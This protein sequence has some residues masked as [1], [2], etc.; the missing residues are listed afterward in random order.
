M[1]PTHITKDSIKKALIYI[2]RYGIPKDRHSVK[3]SLKYDGKLYPPK[4]VISIANKF[5]S[6]E[7]WEPEHFSGGQET[8]Q[9][10]ENL[11]FTIVTTG[12]RSIVYPIESHSWRGI[13]DTVAIKVLDKSAF[14]HHGSGVPRDFKVFFGL[15]KLAPDQKVDITLVHKDRR[16]GA[17]FEMDKALERMRLF[18]RSDFADLL[19]ESL[20]EWYQAFSKGIE[21]DSD[22]PEMRLQRLSGSEYQVDFIRPAEI[23]LDIDADVAEETQTRSE[24]A[25]RYSYSKRYERNPENRKKAIEIHGC[26][27]CICGFDFELV[28]GERGKGFI[29]VHHTKPLSEVEDE[30]V[31]D[32]ATDLVPVCSNC[33]RMIH[34]RKDDVLDVNKVRDLFSIKSDVQNI[35]F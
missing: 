22:R 7:E 18:W 15:D 31:I 10:L 8:N 14:L 35:R 34:R 32:P 26:K 6:G 20:P 33:H 9:Y 12:T 25:A 16:F 24:G 2:D 5:E 27:C 23:K 1:I 29:E 19:K 11:G 17:H 21:L 30:I 13:S 3:Y 28:Y 4:Y